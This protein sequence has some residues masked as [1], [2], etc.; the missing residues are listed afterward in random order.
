MLAIM[1][2][3]MPCNSLLATIAKYRIHLLIICLLS[4]SIFYGALFSHLIG[5]DY[6]WIYNAEYVM[7]KPAG[8]VA[9][10]FK[11]NGSG[12][13]RPLTQNVFFFVLYHLIGLKAI[14]YHIT[15]FL[16][17]LF[18]GL[19]VYNII[20]HICGDHKSAAVGI[21]IFLFS[22]LC[23]SLIS[24]A[25]AF[26]QTGSTFFFVLTLYLYIRG[27]KTQKWSYLTFILC[28]MSGEITSTIPAFVASYELVEKQRG[29]LPSIVKTMAFWIIFA[30]YLIAR[31]FFIGF[32]T[33]GPFGPEYNIAKVLK[34]IVTTGAWLGGITPTFLNC[35][36][37]F[38]W[39]YVALGSLSAFCFFIFSRIIS[40][41]T[42]K[43]LTEYRRHVLLGIIWAIVG[44]LPVILFSANDFSHYTLQISLVGYSLT[45]SALIASIQHIRIKSVSAVA[46]SVLVYLINYCAVYNPYGNNNVEG[47]KVLGVT[48]NKFARDLVECKNIVKIK[49]VYVVSR[50]NDSWLFGGQWESKV[51]LHNPTVVTHYEIENVKSKNGVLFQ[52]KR[53]DLKL[54]SCG[55]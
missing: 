10:F 1:N 20:L 19:F 23:Y 40:V 55:R 3:S 38:P 29:L 13:Y 32:T 27:D 45:V 8:W 47:L 35:I 9:A 16:F 6:W 46:V 18:S 54:L 53:N 36:H 28:L 17:M 51:V 2:K 43:G 34:L 52:Y 4:L 24:W 22:S 48:S 44:C 7:N 37:E 49:N 11:E 42:N 50:Q 21:G 30:I 41:L 39:N 12:F 25:A 14:Y 5:D 26:S 31:F 15:S 33:K